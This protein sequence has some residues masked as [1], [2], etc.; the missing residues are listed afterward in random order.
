MEQGYICEA[1][2]CQSE[3]FKECTNC[4]KKLCRIH[5]AYHSCNANNGASSCSS[6][7]S[8]A[9]SGFFSAKFGRSPYTAMSTYG[10]TNGKLRSSAKL[11]K[12]HFILS[13]IIFIPSPTLNCIFLP[14]IDLLWIQSLY[15]MS[16]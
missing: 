3:A 10:N 14:E 15:H 9:A 7:A 13:G 1:H 6:T 11:Q 4:A 5:F 8:I 2:T 12:L 16:H